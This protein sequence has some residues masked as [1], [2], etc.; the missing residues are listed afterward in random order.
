M[1]QQLMFRMRDCCILI[2]CVAALLLA[3]TDEASSQAVTQWTI[4]DQPYIAGLH[5]WYFSADKYRTWFTEYDKRKIGLLINTV[6]NPAHLIEWMP[7]STMESFHPF[8]I[9]TG[10][11]YFAAK[12]M[13]EV[14]THPPFNAYSD[15]LDL[16][17]KD[18]TKLIELTVKFKNIEMFTLP[19]ENQVGMLMHNVFGGA[20]YFWLWNLYKYGLM[21]PWDIQLRGPLS[22]REKKEACAWISN[23]D[24][25]PMLWQLFPFTNNIVTWNFAECKFAVEVFYVVPAVRN[26]FTEVWIGGMKLDSEQDAIAYLRIDKNNNPI[27]FFIW[28]LPGGISR[29][30]RAIWFTQKPNLK[31]Q[32]KRSQVWLISSTVPEVT[33]LEPNLSL[34]TAAPTA[35][36]PGKICITTSQWN[37]YYPNGLFYPVPFN[38]TRIDEN[39]RIWIPGGQD[40]FFP[41][42]LTANRGEVVE[43]IKADPCNV[44]AS[45]SR[46]MF[47]TVLALRKEQE[48]PPE[49]W[50]TNNVVND[51]ECQ[52]NQYRWDQTLGLNVNFYNAMLDIDLAGRASNVTG[53]E[54]F[55]YD[56]V[57]HEPKVSKIGRMTTGPIL[58]ESNELN[59]DFGE[60][61]DEFGMLQNYPNPFNPQ[62]MIEYTLPSEA[63]VTLKVY[64]S[65]GQEVATLLNNELQETGEQNVEFNS[66]DLPSGV[67]FYRIKAVGTAPMD[68]ESEDVEAT[69]SGKVL[70]NVKKMLLVK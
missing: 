36:I 56:I 30:M 12:T 22:Y 70:V 42:F 40:G 60:G 19:D 39:R 14:L 11:F 52:I 15:M 20:D 51:L 53:S 33:I 9:V 10:R 55:N 13:P 5:Q 31:T 2:F 1:K 65:L 67:Y 58:A 38:P 37:G 41:S 61:P 43:L 7:P 8:K 24:P 6:G 23:K 17:V 21:N 62:T 28:T 68:E 27:A 18:V 25:L 32:F 45:A 16:K 35:T 26:N 59:I 48:I 47:D 69:K 44:T 57:W 29:D 66:S 34:W 54:M 4:P 49:T 46:E 3:S 50:T 63:R 64:N